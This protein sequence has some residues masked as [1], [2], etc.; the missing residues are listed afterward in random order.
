LTGT[1]EA[2]LDAGGAPASLIGKAALVTG[3]GSGIGLAA[4]RALVR[5]GA[6]VTICGRTESRLEAAVV[7][8]RGDAADGARLGLVAC[9]V[10]DEDAVARAVARTVEAFEGIDI[11]V[12]AA[13]GS[14]WMGPIVL[15][16]LDAW[17]RTIDLNVTGTF[18]PLKHAT[19]A[20]V[21]R[22]G[23]SFVA[24]SSIAAPLSH[25][26]LAPYCVGKAG[27]EALV[28]V[29]ADELGRSGVRVNAVRPGLVD[30]ELVAGITAGGPVLDDY[31]EQTPLGRIG[32]PADIATAVRYLA[33]PE[34]AW[35]TGQVLGIDGGQTLR[36][37]PDYTPFAEPLYGSGPL[38]GEVP[39]EGV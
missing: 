7:D 18:L 1:G 20:M 39:G 32:A 36:R 9:D 12:A 38:R 21:R 26:Y 30:T 8:L 11:V 22:G 6:S 25:R 34:S 15:T 31:V 5:D 29:A 35:V 10:T 24:V 23:G 37:G 2:G 33:G 16:P 3:G 14:E 28:K 13:G 19:P 17:R 27:I 4:A